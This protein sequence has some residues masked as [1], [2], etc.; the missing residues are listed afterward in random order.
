MGWISQY[1]QPEGEKVLLEAEI[2]AGEYGGLKI[3]SLQFVLYALSWQRGLDAGD[4][5]VS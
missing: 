5:G 3:F 1:H 4:D 2:Q